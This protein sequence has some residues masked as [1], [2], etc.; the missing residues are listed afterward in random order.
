[1]PNTLV[2]TIIEPGTY[3]VDICDSDVTFVVRSVLGLWKTRGR[4]RLE[5]GTVVAHD[6][7]S[8][9]AVIAD[10]EA[11]SVATGNARRD[12]H[13]RSASFLAAS[14]HPQFHFTSDRVSMNGPHTSLQGR[15]T[16][17]GIES[18]VAVSIRS[19]EE[20]GDGRYQVVGHTAVDRHVLGVSK[21][22]SFIS[23]RVQVVV[24]INIGR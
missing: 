6:D 19:V 22:R 4:F 8:R 1:M 18:S 15:L 7:P 9:S 11:S 5:R 17:R 23:G 10:I 13:L 3:A 14:I 24:T 16:V 2:T 21:Y 12:R 20:V